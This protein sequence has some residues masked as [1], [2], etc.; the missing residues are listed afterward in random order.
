MYPRPTVVIVS[1]KNPQRI[2][3]FVPSLFLM[4]EFTGAKMTYAMEKIPMISPI[5]FSL[6]SPSHSVFFCSIKVGKKAITFW[7]I[8][9]PIH[10]AARVEYRILFFIAGSNCWS[11]FSSC[12]KLSKVLS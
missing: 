10:S 1:K 5:S 2:A 12:S 7:I 9:L 4:I 6:I 8:M 11:L 3:F